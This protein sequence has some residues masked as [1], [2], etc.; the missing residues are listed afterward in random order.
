MFG[1]GCQAFGNAARVAGVLHGVRVAGE[2]GQVIETALREYLIKPQVS[3]TILQYT[4]RRITV[5]G[6]VNKPGT[7]DLPDE[8]SVD[9]ME[10]IV[11]NAPV[12]LCLLGEAGTILASNP[13]FSRI[14]HLPEGVLD[15]RV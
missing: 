15:V 10:A 6:Q 8:A 7:I 9:L 14:L 4:K 2:F 5:L 12:G 1:A 3:V 11:Q 13:A